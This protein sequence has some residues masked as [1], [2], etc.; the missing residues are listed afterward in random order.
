MNTPIE[1]CQNKIMKIMCQSV[2][3]NN[4]CNYKTALTTVF[5][6]KYTKNVHCQMYTSIFVQEL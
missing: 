2:E 3:Y 6:G 1:G 5:F 4:L